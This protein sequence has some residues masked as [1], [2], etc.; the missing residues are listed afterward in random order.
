[1]WKACAI[2]V[3]CVVLLG[4]LA[5]EARSSSGSRPRIGH[6]AGMNGPSHKGWG[7]GGGYHQ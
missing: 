2:V 5:A 7:R 6:H 4:G 3:L 1:M